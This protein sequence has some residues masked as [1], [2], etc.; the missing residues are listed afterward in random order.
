MLLL[1]IAAGVALAAV[2]AVLLLWPKG[3]ETSAASSST[4]PAAGPAQSA[5]PEV[6][7]LVRRADQ[8]FADGR[9]VASDGTSAAELYRDAEKLDPQDARSRAYGFTRSIEDG[10]RSAEQALLAANLDEA[11]RIAASLGLLSPH[12]PA[13]FVPEGAD[14]KGAGPCEP[15]R[16][17]ALDMGSQAGADPLQPRADATA[18]RHEPSAR[19]AGRQRAFALPQR[20][21]GG[22]R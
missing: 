5:Q 16:Q 19:T 17:R 14:Q 18:T 10:L 1:L 13:P 20:G 8:A 7:D 11:S 6:N 2:T 12:E 3:D 15:G 22:S 9:Y 4:A 21:G